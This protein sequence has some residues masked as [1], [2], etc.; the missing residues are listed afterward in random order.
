MDPSGQEPT[1]EQQLASSIAKTIFR[2]NGQ[3]VEVAEQ[4]AR[5]AGLT[6]A[7]WRVLGGVIDGPLP[8]AEISRRFGVARQ[9]VQPVADLLVERG[10]A[11]YR[12]NPA[13]R[14]AKLVAITDEGRAAVRRIGP[15]HRAWS[16]R[17]VAELG[18]DTLER[19]LGDLERL[20]DAM[21]VVATEQPV[22]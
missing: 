2:L 9:S 4:F 21:G 12:P 14:R 7:W 10:L 11:E 16:A 19:M 17:L 18:E 20:A 22:A 13:H 3:L 6:A 1:A 15:A 8:V 5:P